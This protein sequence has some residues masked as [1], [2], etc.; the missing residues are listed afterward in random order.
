M[1][2]DRG[3][4]DDRDRINLSPRPST[5]RYLRQL[6]NIDL[7]GADPTAVA[8]RLVE[9]GIRQALERG[10]IHAEAPDPPRRTQPSKGRSGL[11]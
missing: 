5:V 10:L 9:D 2:H 6:V 11:A 4:A 8:T 1:T 3:M 7:Y